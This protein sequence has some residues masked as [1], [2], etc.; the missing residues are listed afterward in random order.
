MNKKSVKL[1]VETIV[2]DM[3]EYDTNNIIT[4]H[5]WEYYSMIDIISRTVLFTIP[6]D[7]NHICNL[8]AFPGYS[9]LDKPY[10]LSS[11]HNG[12]YLINT[13]QRTIQKIIEI[14]MCEKIVFT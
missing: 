2:H 6:S 3:Y 12:L 11:Q 5:G 4:V 1:I 8:L 13:K 10:L 7:R 9:Y 14:R